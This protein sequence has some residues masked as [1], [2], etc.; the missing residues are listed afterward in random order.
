MPPTTA[1]CVAPTAPKEIAWD[2]QIHSG[3]F[4]AL[5]VPRPKKR[6]QSR[7][8]NVRD[9]WN[10]IKFENRLSCEMFRFGYA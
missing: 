4:I 5:G 9:H 2:A 3:G 8:P 1:R 7:A 6:P 10:T